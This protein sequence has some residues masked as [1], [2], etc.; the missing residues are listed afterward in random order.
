MNL[1]IDKLLLLDDLVKG[2]KVQF[3]AAATPYTFLDKA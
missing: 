2:D 1:D 3:V